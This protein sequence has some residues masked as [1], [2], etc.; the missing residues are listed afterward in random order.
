MNLIPKWVY[1]FSNQQAL[2]NLSPSL[3]PN[4]KTGKTMHFLDMTDDYRKLDY[5]EVAK[6]WAHVRF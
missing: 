2:K 3:S 1:G 6:K 5:R 4:P